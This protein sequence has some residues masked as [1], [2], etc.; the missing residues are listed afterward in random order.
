MKGQEG[1]KLLVWID[2]H[3][4]WLEYCGHCA[5][6]VNYNLSDD[7]FSIPTRGWCYFSGHGE[8]GSF[9]GGELRFFIHQR[10]M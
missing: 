3:C 8:Q 7:S 10:L 1:K 5:L 4:W 2:L 6:H 9:I